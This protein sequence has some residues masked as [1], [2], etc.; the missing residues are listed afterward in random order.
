M[1][2]SSQRKIFVSFIK[3]ARKDN[4]VAKKGESYIKVKRNKYSA[5]EYFKTTKEL[6]R[7][8]PRE[9]TIS[10]PEL[11]RILKEYEESNQDVKEFVKI[12]FDL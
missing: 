12:Y 11:K 10:E 3:K 4:S 7:K 5:P 6:D 9:I 8:Y 2:Y 1:M